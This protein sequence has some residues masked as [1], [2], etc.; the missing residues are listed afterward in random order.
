MFVSIDFEALGE[1]Y[2]AI[3]VGMVAAKRDRIRVGR[4]D[5]NIA[6]PEEETPDPDTLKWFNR[7][8]PEAFKRC[9]SEPILSPAQATMSIVQFLESMQQ[10]GKVVLVAYP[11]FY[12]GTM[13]RNYWTRYNPSQRIP[14]SFIDIRSFA[15]GKL[16]IPL[17]E[18]SK[19]KGLAR[20][21]PPAGQFPHTHC[22]IDDA[23]EQ[24]EL[25]FNI[26]SAER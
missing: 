6:L 8:N 16:G 25:F 2:R 26:M 21:L 10:H 22:G 13:L 14:Y 20:F 17:S 19:A 15:A 11:T 24:L 9:T 7:E 18:A 4:L 1:G 23:E 3:N 12:D 5:I